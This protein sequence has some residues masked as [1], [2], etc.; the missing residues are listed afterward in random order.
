[1]NN[2]AGLTN[3]SLSPTPRQ[4]VAV[5]ETF[6]NVYADEE[7]ARAYA[8]LQFPGTYFLA[9][10]DLPGLIRRHNHG[11]RALDFGCGTGRSTRFLR[12]LGLHVI[13]ADIS[14][15]M[16]DHA[17]GL[18][19]SGEYQFIRNSIADEFAPATFDLVLA[20]FTFDNMPNEAKADALSALRV[21][22]ATNGCLLL[23]VSSPE[24]YFNEWASFSTRDF[25][26]NRDARD[27]DRVRIIMLDVPDRRPVEDVFCTDAHYRRLFEGA[28][29][30]VLDIQKPLATGRETTRWISETKTP[31]WTIYILGPAP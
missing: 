28:G 27:G 31:A 25:Q 4:K 23:V 5:S 2:R 21:L 8:T 6:S 17:R 26:E 7:R 11:S 10:R 20:A 29:L 15:A 14:E 13:G 19:P 24:I 9:F 22:L 16:L 30:G 18:D 3:R 1:V 12:N